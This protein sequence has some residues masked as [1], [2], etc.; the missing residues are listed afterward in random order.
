M[1]PFTRIVS[2]LQML[3]QPCKQR[4]AHQEKASE[5]FIL[6]IFIIDP[7]LMFLAASGKIDYHGLGG[8]DQCELVFAGYTW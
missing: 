7:G 5:N 6:K 1:I 8:G 2:E 4:L 3:V